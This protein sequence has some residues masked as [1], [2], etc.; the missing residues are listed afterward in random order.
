MSGIYYKGASN[1]PNNHAKGCGNLF[2]NLGEN[3]S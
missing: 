1:I 2:Y 3:N